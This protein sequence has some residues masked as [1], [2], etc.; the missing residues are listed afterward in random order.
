MAPN[1]SPV[2]PGY[3]SVT[4][5]LVVSDAA[6]AIEFYKQAF[7]ATE[8]SRMEGPHGKIGHAEL[9][10]GNSMLMLSDEMPGWGNPSPATLGGS[11]VSLFLYLEDVDS[12]YSRALQ[13][14]AQ[15][16]MEPTDQ[17]WGDRY[18]KIIDPFGHNWGLATHVEDV[19]P[20]EIA[21]RAE[22]Q[23]AKMQ[24]SMAQAS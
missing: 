11:P 17:F 13:A 9:R 19:S 23:M 4:P 12:V 2:P 5:Y 1:V 20:E 22:L 6:K 16:T 24:Q 15:S 14:G 3:N 7:G 8:V 18:G 21:R 10:I